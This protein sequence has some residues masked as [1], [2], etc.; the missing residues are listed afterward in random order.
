MDETSILHGGFAR[1]SNETVGNLDKAQP[2]YGQPSPP[3]ISDLGLASILVFFIFFP[4]AIS[5]A[6]DSI[7]SMQFE[8]LKVFC[9][10]A[11]FRSFSQAASAHELTQSAASQIVHQL[12]KRLDVQL[13]DR[14]T[15][16]LQ[17]TPL[18]Q[19]YFDGCKV[20]VEQYEELETSIRSEEAQRAT[21]V[22]VAAI[23]SVGLG[24]MGQLIERFRTQYAPARVHMEYVHPDSVYEKVLE[25]TA[26]LGL[27]SF[28]R[29]QRELTV[30]PWR[31]ENMIL[32][33]A[34]HHPLARYRSIKPSQLEN[35]AYV[36]FT[37]DLS[38]RRRVDQFLRE[39]E[40][41]VAV[42]SEFDTIENIKRA[43]EVG[44]GVALLPEPTFAQEVRAGTLVARPLEGCRFIRPIGIIHRRQPRLSSAAHRFIALLQECSTNAGHGL[45]G[46]TTNGQ[47]G[48]AARSRKTAATRKR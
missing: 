24:G 47:A 40:V 23:Y 46:H 11:R 16:P 41:S 4:L 28:P 30:L 2:K 25:R 38:I 29:K 8:A 32:A 15:R 37:K 17:L 12:E 35:I 1:I 18:G 31:N 9:D 45:N 43:I 27:V 20:L 42:E 3:I 10:I 34:P 14:S 33:C 6:N 13:I 22:E 5:N 19:R 44:H 26:E 48:H 39:H 36:A 21:S 7:L